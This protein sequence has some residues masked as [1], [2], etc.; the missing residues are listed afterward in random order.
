MTDRPWLRFYDEGVPRT[1]AYPEVALHTFLDDTA[2]RTPDA[3]ATIFLTERLRSS[4]RS[5][6]RPMSPVGPR[7]DQ[8]GVTL[9]VAVQ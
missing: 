2:R 5:S 4:E 9:R 7:A 6:E 1:I 3:I 8:L